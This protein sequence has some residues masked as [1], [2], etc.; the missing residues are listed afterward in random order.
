[1]D[2]IK[3]RTPGLSSD[4]EPKYTL[5]GDPITVQMYDSMPG[6][7]FG[8]INPILYTGN[9]KDPVSLELVRNRIPISMPSRRLGGGMS[10]DAANIE[11]K[12]TGVDLTPEQYGWFVK[13]AGNGLKDPKTGRGAW[14]EVTAIING[15]I[16]ADYNYQKGKKPEPLYYNQKNPDGTPVF[17]D[18]PEGGKAFII[19]SVLLAARNEVRNMIESGEVFPDL[20]VAYEEK[21]MRKEIRQ[22]PQVGG[23]R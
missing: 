21:K 19:T 6:K 4:L 3:S 9:T 23:A 16:P 7:G 5:R 11:G 15:D 10:P 18:G 20:G 22:A 13:M 2:V 17:S 14:D 12:E 1:M 8:M